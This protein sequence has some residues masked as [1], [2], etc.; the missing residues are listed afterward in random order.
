ML[1]KKSKN[2]EKLK[3]VK[4]NS[5]S[6]KKYKKITLKNKN[7]IKYFFKI[8]I[9]LI[10]LII[11]SISLTKLISMDFSNNTF[12][13]E[14]QIHIYNDT[15]N[16][17]SK[18]W[19][20]MTAINPPSDSIINLEKQLK[21]WKIVVIGNI[22]TI[23]SN[24]DIFKNSNNLVY[25]SLN[26]QKQLEYNILKFLKDDSYCRKNIGYLFAIQHGAKKIY[27]IDEN[28][29]LSADDEN[30]MDNI[31]DLYICYAVKNGQSMI[32]PYVHFGETNIWPRG[33]LIKDI[34]A[35]YNKSFYYAYSSQVK[36]K[37][38]IYQ[39]LINVVPDTDSIFL[40]TS[41]KMKKNL[42]INF[43]QNYP[44]L[45]LPGNYVPINSKNTKYLYEIFPFLM[46]PTTINE[47][48][49]DII[50][51][52]ILERFAF[53][54]E[55]MIVY[56]NSKVYR[57]NE[58]INNDISIFKEREIL[59]NLDK[60]LDIIK[61]DQLYS[62]KSPLNLFFRILSE[63]IK[64]NFL[65]PEEMAVYESFLDDLNNIGYEYSKNN[66]LSKINNNYMDYLNFTSELIYYLPPNPNIITG[67]NDT[68]KIYSH[69]S[70]NKNYNDI[71]LIINYNMPG[72][73]K[74]NEYLEELYKKYFPNIVY[75]YPQNIKTNSPNIIHCEE[76]YRGYFS[77]K[78]MERIHRRFP[79]YKGYL[80][81]NDD[82][83]LKVWELENFDFNIPWLYKYEP[84]GI[85]QRWV[86]YSM[87][88]GLKNI[89]EHNLEYKANLTNF[90]G[91]YKV[92]NG[93]A[94]L[95]YIPKY[96]MSS[97]TELLGKMYGAK[98]FLE[99]A[100]PDSFAIM[101]APKYQ[102]IYVRPIWANERENVFN[103]LHKEYQ[104][105]SIH[106]IKFSSKEAKQV[107]NKYN[108]FI[109]ANDF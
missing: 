108:Y 42:N 31:N 109:N 93:F 85:N 18:R 49:A 102:I 16:I 107:V 37:P 60:I 39:G 78:C 46:L 97:F 68:Y 8:P 44:L 74:L 10:L 12:T 4:F 70:C 9:K 26:A 106:P 32:N 52:Y 50:R 75:L 67:D 22:K 77:Y 51:G 80:L 89:C 83:Y 15:Y 94:D 84:G 105:F 103:I 41:G 91:M 104:Q 6:K 98:I 58:G 71:L 19:I 96:Y 29:I 33:F 64:Y 17:N 66:F 57:E 65:K 13:I 7:L 63:L 11:L 86:F 28:L 100:I 35:D 5:K 76:S 1:Y 20:V 88:K 95:Y 87:C 21:N 30:F 59:F 43:C 40:L 3:K 90:F 99:C 92:F 56:H 48:I 54:Y 23:D 55:G 14:K 101:S 2:K 62:G 69:S 73:L 79:N 36:I 61:S 34:M 38:L 47:S 81:T 27:E 53:G 24:W 82:N 45:Y 25:L 72:F